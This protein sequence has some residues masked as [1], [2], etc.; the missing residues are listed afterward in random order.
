MSKILITAPYTEA[1]IEELKSLFDTVIYQPWT[2]RGAAYSAE[3]LKVLLK[4]TAADALISELDDL[5]Q[6]VIDAWEPKPQFVAICRA[7][8]STIDTNALKEQSIPLFTAPSRNIQAVTELFVGN[9][10]TFYRQV[11]ESEQWLKAGNWTDWLYPYKEFRGQQL[12]GKKVGI[13]GLGLVGRHIAK[14]LEAFDCE[15]S[16]YDPF[17]KAEDYPQYKA[18]S[19]EALFSESEIVT[20]HLPSIP[21]T[22]RMITKE[23]LGLMKPNTLFVNTSRASV[24]DNAALIE[25][26]E[27]REILGAVIDIFDH[28]PPLEEDMRLIRLDNVLATPHIAGSTYEVVR[29]HSEIINASIKQWHAAKQQAGGGN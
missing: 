2:D 12:H 23:L 25:R 10:I 7:T 9:I 13:V 6:D 22:K 14:M 1:A 26:L 21:Q 28:E 4:E 15:I 20:V 24:V 11:R 27:K 8:P 29:N 3:E 19:L 16:F 17:V 18:V 5:N